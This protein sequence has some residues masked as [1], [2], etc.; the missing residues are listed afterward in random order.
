MIVEELP[1]RNYQYKSKRG[2]SERIAKKYFLR[3]G[4]EVFRGTMLLGKEWSFNYDKYENVQKKY[5]RIEKILMDFLGLRIW[6][7]RAQLAF[8]GIPDFFVYKK[9][10]MHFVEVKLEHEQI[11]PHQLQCMALLE[12]YG[13]QTRVLRIK[14]RPFRLRTKVELDID[15]ATTKE[16]MKLSNRIVLEKQKKMKINWD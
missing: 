13:F 10:K 12:R 8:G 16:N 14:Q 11:K 5:D 15:P 3:L 6:S 9:R 2:L 4:Y 7:L 1:L